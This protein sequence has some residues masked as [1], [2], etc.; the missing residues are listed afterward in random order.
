MLL[1]DKMTAAISAMGD[2]TTFAVP[3][4]GQPILTTIF[5]L[6]RVSYYGMEQWQENSCWQTLILM[7]DILYFHKNECIVFVKIFTKI[8]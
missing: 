3:L 2:D 7:K 8:A 4:A 5:M 1:I 6:G